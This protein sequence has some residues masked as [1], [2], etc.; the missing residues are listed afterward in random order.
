[1][2]RNDLEQKML[3]RG[4][5]SPPPIARSV[6]PVPE[7]EFLDEVHVILCEFIPPEHALEQFLFMNDLREER[8]RRVLV[9]PFQMGPPHAH[10]LLKGVT[11]G[12][13]A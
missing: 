10:E 3:R 6:R 5:A 9:P 1:M 7:N 12:T 8:R 13:V 2:V 11:Q 4:Q